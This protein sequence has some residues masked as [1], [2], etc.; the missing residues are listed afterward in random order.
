MIDMETNEMINALRGNGDLFS[1]AVAN[2]L[3]E[4]AAMNRHLESKVVRA[5]EDKQ[6]LRDQYAEVMSAI[7]NL[8]NQYPN[9]I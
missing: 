9:Y 1:E 7:K 2:R 4:L 5:R 3:E 6:Y 8:Y